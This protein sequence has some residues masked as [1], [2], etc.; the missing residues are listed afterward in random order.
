MFLPAVATGEA[1][2]PGVPELRVIRRPD[3]AA[4]AEKLRQLQAGRRG[5]LQ[6]QPTGLTRLD[7]ALGGGFARSCI[8]EL[9][10]PGEA[11][12]A[13]SLA[14]WVAARLIERTADTFGYLAQHTADTAV[15]HLEKLAG[16]HG[17]E[18]ARGHPKACDPEGLRL[19][20]WVFY[21]DTGGDFYPPAAAQLGLPLER[22]LVVR[23]K[24]NAD[25]LWVCEQ[26]LRCQAVAVVVL[27]VRTIDTYASRRLQLA[28][29]TGGGLGFLLRSD[30]RGGHTFAAT[31]L[32]LDPLPGTQPG[33]ATNGTN[34]TGWHGRVGREG[35]G[36][37][38][39]AP[40]NPTPGFATEGASVRE[41]RPADTIVPSRRNTADTAVP[42]LE[43]FAG[44]Y[45]LGD[46]AIRRMWVTLLKLRDGRPAEPFELILPLT[47]PGGATPAQ[48]PA[49][50][51]AS[52]PR[53]C[54]PASAS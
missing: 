8:H 45:D 35:T 26:A 53:S 24:R 2:D 34:E 14:F 5:P 49:A 19:T 40:E 46:R 51:P 17:R 39:N 22:L 28:A 54:P 50:T 37:N 27:P 23:A 36:P 21:I 43:E 11:A 31:R 44:W 6:R 10:A 18:S 42:H 47:A 52:S 20:K 4:L 15:P 33:P 16:W 12:P 3:L 32:R 38:P 1:P 30:A 25:A 41:E 29:E 9:L 7:A 13:R 48:E